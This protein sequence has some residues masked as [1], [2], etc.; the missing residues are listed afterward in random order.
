MAIAGG[1]IPSF[2]V[3][4]NYRRHLE[5]IG[6]TTNVPE[7]KVQRDMV[8]AAETLRRNPDRAIRIDA[9]RYAD[10]QA[11]LRNSGHIE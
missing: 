3:H 4:I 5:P 10:L 9:Q 1:G 11:Y 2:W 7:N 6:M 8:L